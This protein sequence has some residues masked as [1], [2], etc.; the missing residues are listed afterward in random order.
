MRALIV[1][2]EQNIR[3]VL[4]IILSESDFEVHEASRIEEARVLIKDY[5][6]DMALIDLRLPD[7]LGIDVLKEIKDTTPETIVLV[8]T[9]FA[10]AETAIETMKAGA[11]DYIMKPFNIDE[12]RIIINNIKDKILLQKRVHELQKFEDTF[13][14]IVG[15]SEAI[16]NVFN[17]IEK[18]APFDTNVLITG[19]S[20]TGKEL[21][22][23]AIHKRSDRADKPLV[24]INCASLPA[25][26][27]ESELFGYVRGAFTG[28][29]TSKRGLIEEANKG[30]LFLDEIGEMPRSLQAKFLRFLEER[31]IRPIGSSKEIAVDIRVI[32]ATNKDLN[33]L[34]DSGAFRKDLYY[35]LT[36]FE[37]KLPTLKE[38]SEDIPLLIEHFTKLFSKKFQKNI[39][40][41]EPSF[42]DYVMKLDLK[43]NVRELKNI[44]EREVILSEN[45]EIKCTPCPA[46]P[47]HDRTTEDVPEKGIDLKEYL[48]SIEKEM[49]RKAMQ[50]ANG[51]KTKA[52]ELLGLTFREFRYKLSKYK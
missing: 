48:A 3:K 17:L 28:A 39:S 30:I 9:A 32:A 26:L 33:S 1:D 42:I 36:A 43:G 51:I 21:V 4:K 35:R 11:Y 14:G 45:G 20:G 44:V 52:A 22:S 12:I 40:K 50:K 7:G 25:E 47:N 41:I 24:A 5:V 10:S 6:F 8:I 18:I 37:I 2:D 46:S 19:E 16:K 34:F 15:Q 23:K 29:Y 38:R 13:E 31:K 27:L 49:L